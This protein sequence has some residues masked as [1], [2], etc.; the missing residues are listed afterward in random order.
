MYTDTKFR[1]ED[2][3]KPSALPVNFSEIPMELK[4]IPRWVLWN[5]TEVGSEGNRHWSKIPFQTDGKQ[6]KANDPSTWTDFLSVQAAYEKNPN[7]FSGIGFVFSD[8]DNLIGVD[9]DKCYD[10]SNGFTNVALQQ[11]ADSI[12][13][14]MEVS[15]SGKGVKIFT[16]A[17]LRVAHVDHSIGFECYPH[18]RYFTVTGHHIKGEI[19][20]T[21]QNIVDVIPERIAHITGDDF[22]DYKPPVPEYDLARVESE[23]LSQLSPDCGYL[24]WL[25]IGQAL[26]H[27]FKGDL[28]ACDLWDR[29]SYADGNYPKYAES[30]KYSCAEKWRSFRRTAGSTFTLR[31]LIF[32]VNQKQRKEALERG[33]IILDNGAMNHART[34]LDGM[35]SSEEGYTLVHYADEFYSHVNTHYEII[36]EL[37]VRS[38]LYTFLDKCKKSGKKGALEAFNPSPASVSAAL[39]AIKSLTHLPNHAN[40]KP[41]IWLEKYADNQPDS[42]DLIS[43]QNGIFHLKDYTVLPHSLGFFTPNSL[44]FPYDAN[45]K[46]PE[47]MKFLNSVWSEDQESIDCLQEMMGY[48]LSGDTRQQKF[49]NIIGPRRSGKGTINKVLV[50]L[51][52]QHNTVAPQLEELCDTFGLQP[53]LGKLLASFTDARAPERNRSA[54]VSQLLRIV[55]GDTVTVNRKNKEAWNGYLPTRIVVYSNEALQLTENSN[56]LTGRMIVIKMTKSFFGDEDTELYPRLAKELSGIFNWAMEGL[57]RRLA[58]GGHFIQPKSGK[59]LL[60]LM[61]ELGNP[62]GSFVEDVLEF[63]PTDSVPKDDVFACYKRWALSKSIPP[64]TELA[65]KRRF[66]AATQEHQI[67]VDVDRSNGGRVHI[68]R[69]VRLNEKAKRYVESIQSFTEDVF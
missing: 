25:N 33:E 46:C 11:I 2:M 42:K 23:L 65:F 27:Q 43:L 4:Q 14:Y 1:K 5:H 32:K 35:Y 17:M 52:G 58:R 48:I 13:G 40:T 57:K 44:P 30:G 7:R 51:L 62:I 24:D 63:H 61:A 34:F 39:D 8:E 64:G 37:T 29:W 56:A 31:S 41:P 26:H 50:E 9:L 12:D 10:Q 66:L 53:W 38:K 47:W 49:F 18:G 28:E 55:G 59:H 3:E 54:V 68:Y 16:R 22:A 21:E 69:G 20:T 45:A 15:P 36:E 60:E 19:P 67:D 6:A